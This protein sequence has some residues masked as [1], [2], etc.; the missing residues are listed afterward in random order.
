MESLITIKKVLP[1]DLRRSIQ[2]EDATIIAQ[3]EASQKM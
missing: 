1:I 2:N 3:E